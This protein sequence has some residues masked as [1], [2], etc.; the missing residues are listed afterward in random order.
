MKTI[1]IVLIFPI[2]LIVL[3]TP[4]FSQTHSYLWLVTYDSSETIAS[5]IQVPEGYERV[6][7]IPCTFADWLRHLPLKKG[8]PPVYLYNGQKKNNQH[9]HFAVVDIDVGHKDL[10]QCADAVIRLQA[11]YLYSVRNYA[12]IHFNYTSGDRSD[13]SEWIKGYRPV[14]K[15]NKVSWIKSAKVDTSYY[16]F[17]KYLDMVF[18][19]A[20]SYS[21]NKELHCVQNVEEMKI[22]DIFIEDGFPGHAVIVVDMAIHKKTDKKLFVLAQSYM[23]AQD[24]HILIN[25]SNFKLNPWYVLDFGE[26]LYTPEWN[27]RR[28]HLKRF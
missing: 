23:P 24:I 7:T 3:I 5:R 17:R 20:G 25:P 1:A 6:R 28:K 4:G 18:T 9:A 11:E 15:G 16:N 19:Y 13:F 26:T 12:A 14:V 22:G 10:Q 2:D 21:V 27:F 8:K